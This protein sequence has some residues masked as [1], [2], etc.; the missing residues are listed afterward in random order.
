MD[1][2][3]WYAIQ[4]AVLSCLINLIIMLCCQQICMWHTQRTIGVSGFKLFIIPFIIFHELAHYISALMF[5]FRQVKISIYNRTTGVLGAVTYV[6][7]VN[8][9][10]KLGCLVTSL[11]PLIFGVFTIYLIFP[12]LFGQ[13][14]FERKIN[15][16]GYISLMIGQLMNKPI[17]ILISLY[18]ISGI[19]IAMS[20]SIQDYK[21]AI[22]GLLIF[23]TLLICTWALTSFF[24]DNAITLVIYYMA[25]LDKI[26]SVASVLCITTMIGVVTA[27]QI[28]RL[29]VLRR[30]K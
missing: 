27:Q 23:I 2:N 1:V 13:H 15:H 7:R 30:V 29:T 22:P 25:M 4:T 5:G 8:L 18:F 26:L 12:E 14:I 3:S 19:C 6:Y 9:L 21:V 17:E 28:L 16:S 10:G 20:P 11:A 24:Y